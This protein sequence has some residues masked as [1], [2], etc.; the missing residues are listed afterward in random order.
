MNLIAKISH[1]ECIETI[2]RIGG[3]IPCFLLDKEE[4]ISEYKF[5]MTFQNPDNPEEFLSIFIPD[6]YSLRLDNN[7]IVLPL[8]WTGFS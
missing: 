3:N 5:Y 4:D 6:N 8:N 2:G 1:E 7:I